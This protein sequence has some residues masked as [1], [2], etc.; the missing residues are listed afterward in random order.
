MSNGSL[1]G[2]ALPL[3]GKQLAQCTSS[4]PHSECDTSVTSDTSGSDWSS[5]DI[6]SVLTMDPDDPDAADPTFPDIQIQLPGKHLLPRCR[7]ST[8]IRTRGIRLTHESPQPTTEEKA[9]E[10]DCSEDNASHQSLLAV[11]FPRCREFQSDWDEGSS[12]DEDSTGDARTQC[13]PAKPLHSTGPKK[14]TI[15]QSNHDRAAPQA[16]TTHTPLQ[17]KAATTKDP[18]TGGM[19]TPVGP[20]AI[21]V[22][23]PGN[24]E[25]TPCD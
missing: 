5:Q 1:G 24:P 10:P 3:Q 11:K 4:E 23:P 6:D 15:T 8:R 20:P 12:P 21:P 9:E 18:G 17:K 2:K 13:P 25:P 22:A 7:R 14:D 16:T 19:D